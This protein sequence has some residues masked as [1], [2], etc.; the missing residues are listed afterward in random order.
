MKSTDS[1]GRRRLLRGAAAATAVAT[2]AGA[3]TSAIAQPRPAEAAVTRITQLLDT[4]PDQQELSRD[5]S[6]GIR[7]AFAELR[8]SNVP[9]PLL[10][11]VETDAS[12]ASVRNA[13]QLIKNDTAQVALIGA[14]GEGLAL[15]SLREAAQVRLEIAHVAPWLADSRFDAGGNLFSLFASREDQ[16]R[17][18]M[19]NF[20]AMGV[21]EL[22]IVYPNP[23]LEQALHAGLAEA[24]ER[25]KL[26]ARVLT[27]P[28]GKD[29][30]AFASGL[31]P[32]IPVFLL[33]MGG[34]IDLARFTQGL[35]RKGRQRYL[36]CLSDVDI[37]SFLQFNPGKAVPVVFTRVVPNPMSSKVPVVRA[38]R[39]ALARLFD[40]A[41]SPMSLAGYL[42]GRYAANVLGAAG[43]NAGRARVLAE[44]QKRRSIE[45]DGYRVA[46]AGNGRAGG[47]V[48]QILLNSQGGFVE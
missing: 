46:F 27:V 31:A 42:A 39:E 38:Y 22:G 19:K 45:F 5:Y 2:L 41:P 18:V 9:L 11:T 40:E 4:S 6:T 48:S 12:P 32:D 44:F 10:S 13:L 37:A 3:A 34:S 21:T 1:T 33:F 25:L 43:P 14:V 7:L 36:V 24:T 35:D 17:Y 29:I 15:A 30:A 26:K 8:K 47:F 16:I 23:M 28:Q 20:A